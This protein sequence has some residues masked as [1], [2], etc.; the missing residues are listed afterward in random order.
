M[1]RL[2]HVLLHGKLVGVY[3]GKVPNG[4]PYP[5]IRINVDSGCTAN[6]FSICTTD[7]GTITGKCMEGLNAILLETY[8]Q[9]ES[10]DTALPFA[11]ATFPELQI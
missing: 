8:P 6:H 11:L 5:C 1:E 7:C 9:L 3:Y 10:Y 4:T 2:I